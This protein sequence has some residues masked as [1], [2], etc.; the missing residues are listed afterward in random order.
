MRYTLLTDYAPI[1]P[2]LGQR[3]DYN[4]YQFV[5]WANRVKFMQPRRQLLLVEPL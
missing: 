3:L 4:F 2:C 5:D 1:R